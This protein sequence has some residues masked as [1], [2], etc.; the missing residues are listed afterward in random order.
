M[1]EPKAN[2]A[3]PR[4]GLFWVVCILALVLDQGVKVAQRTTMTVGESIPVIDGWLHL[5]YRLNTGAA[6]SMLAG[7]GRLLAITAPVALLAIYVF[8]RWLRP[9]GRMPAVATG[10]I[11]AGAIGN[12]IDRLVYG[13]VTD[14]ID[15]RV[16]DFAVF[17]VADSAI[18]VGGILLA[19][20][21]VF[22]G[23]IATL[24]NRMERG[25]DGE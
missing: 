3:R 2:T 16:I 12:G 23:G 6:F 1:T 13:S 15:V 4:V 22:F 17:N 25:G 5:T 24:E 11:A 8:W 19:A 14:I 10:L 21:M 20:W 9:E 18:T 7:N